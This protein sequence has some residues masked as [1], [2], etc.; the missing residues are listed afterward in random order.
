MDQSLRPQRSPQQQPQPIMP[1]LA[2]TKPSITEGAI[3]PSEL[4]GALA[5]V[6]GDHTPTSVTV[7]GVV[8]SWRYQKGWGSG[9]L[10]AYGPDS[11]IVAKIPFGIPRTAM[12]P[13]TVG[14]DM[15]VAVTG[16]LETSPPWHTIR[17]QGQ[18][19]EIVAVTSTVALSRTTL[20]E[21]F[22]A[23]G[24]IDHQKRLT[25]PNTVG[26]V[27]LITAAASAARADII[28]TLAATKT[29]VRV[30]EEHVA[31]TGT[32]ATDQIVR[33]ITKLGQIGVAVLII[34]RGGGG[35]N[36]LEVFD[37]HDVADAIATCPIPVITAIGHATNTTVA[38]RVAHTNVVTPTAAA[39]LITAGHQ[40]QRQHA[41]DQAAADRLREAALE[42]HVARQQAKRASAQRRTLLIMLAIMVVFVAALGTYAFIR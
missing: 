39:V 7:E 38:D 33:A 37:S 17:L 30:V 6:L 35:Q 16:R 3:N 4:M 18:R 20:L 41:K 23:D 5:R 24:R 36:D 25:L 10:C 32:T 1:A 12:P 19:L 22:T 28:G 14:N 2:T 26:S 42:A 27:G 29:P 9:D 40:R 13:D 31:F 21:D 11:K 8:T 34:A 15:I